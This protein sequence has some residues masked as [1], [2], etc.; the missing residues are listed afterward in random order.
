[1]GNIVQKEWMRDKYSTRLKAAIF[2]LK[3]TLSVLYIPMQSSAKEL[4][5]YSRRR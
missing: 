3:T 1:M 4:P 2:H 5:S